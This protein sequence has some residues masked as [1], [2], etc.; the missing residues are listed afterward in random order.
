MLATHTEPG[1]RLFLT[2]IGRGSLTVEPTTRRVLALFTAE[3]DRRVVEAFE[4]YDLRPLGQRLEASCGDR[5]LAAADR[6]VLPCFAQG[7]LVIKDNAGEPRTVSAGIGALVA[8]A[9]SG[10]GTTLV[11]RDDGTLSR[12]PLTSTTSEKIEPFR[13]ARLVADGI[14]SP[15]PQSFAIALETSDLDLA[16]SET[17]SGRRYLS[18]PRKDTPF[19]GLLAQGQFA[20][21]SVGSAARHIDLFQGFAETM[22]TFSGTTRALPGGVG[23]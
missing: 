11:G 12:I 18:F 13:P 21:W 14:A 23:Q 4:P 9:I 5:V 3:N 8:A 7:A 10:D 1:R 2:G 15:D 17:R 22:A 20:F 19:G 6:V 16:V